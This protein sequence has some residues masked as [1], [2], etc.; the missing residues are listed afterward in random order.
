MLGFAFRSYVSRRLFLN[1][2]ASREGSETEP[3]S[4]RASPVGSGLDLDTPVGTA[5]LRFPWCGSILAG[6]LFVQG[7]SGMFRVSGLRNFKEPAMGL[8]RAQG[9]L[10][11]TQWFEAYAGCLAQDS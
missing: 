2:F 11:S 5:T 9:R 10:G 3:P 8:G 1:S 7:Y 4:S 6:Q